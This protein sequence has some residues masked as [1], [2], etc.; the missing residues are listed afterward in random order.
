MNSTH[1]PNFRN[2]RWVIAHALACVMATCVLADEAADP[3]QTPIFDLDPFAVQVTRD[4]GFV[5]ATSQAGG[6]MSTE[7]AETAAAYSVQT[8][9]FLEALNITSSNEALDWTVNATTTPDDGGGQLFGGTGSSTI[10]GVAANQQNRNFF[11]GGSNAPT[12]NVER[13]DYARGPNSVLFGTGSISGTSNVVSKRAQLGT[14]LSEVRVEYGSWDTYG[15]SFDF[16]R[17]LGAD[18]AV[19]VT[20]THQ[21]TFTW[22]DWERTT[23]RG[24]AP[25]FSYRFNQKTRLTVL[26]DV[27]EQN[28][29]RGMASLTDSV[30]GWDGVTTYAGIQPAVAQTQ[31]GASR[32]FSNSFIWNPASGAPANALVNQEGMMRTQ[33]YLGQ[34]PINGVWPLVTTNLGLNLAPILDDPLKPAGIYDAAIAGSQFRIP[35]RK[36][37]AIGPNLTSYNKFGSGTLFVDHR[38][39]ENISLQLSGNTNE[40]RSYGFIGYFINNGYPHVYIDLNQ[41]LHDGTPNPNFL[42][43]YNEFTRPERQ[44][45]DTAND[46]LRFAAAYE[47]NHGWA[48]VRANLITA[49]ENEEQLRVRE[50]QVL[51]VDA[52]SRQW[53]LLTSSRARTF[54]YRYYWDQ[55]ERR[56]P[57]LKEVTLIDPVRGTEATYNPLWALATDRTDGTLLARSLTKYAQASTSLA[58][59]Q[60]RLILFGAYRYDQVDRSQKQFMAPMDHPAGYVI[61]GRDFLYRPDAPDDYWVM[62]YVPKDSMGNQMDIARPAVVR[63]RDGSGQAQAVYANDRFQDDYN[64]PSV[65][66]KVSTEAIGAVVNLGRGVSLWANHAETFNPANLGKTTINFGTPDSS[67][68][69][70][71]DIGIRYSLG[72]RLALSLSYYQS[73]EANAEIVQPSGYSNINVI[74]QSNPVGDFSFDGRNI[75]NIGDRPP[76][77]SDQIDR[78]TQGWEFELTANPTR[79]WRVTANFGTADAGQLNAYRQTRDWVA[80]NEAVLRQ[81]LEDAGV[82]FDA[83]GVAT[84]RTDLDS[85]S[86][87]APQAAN[88]WNALQA[89]RANWVSGRQLMFQSTRWTANFYTDV[90]ITETFLK[91][92]R[93]GY[94]MQ[95]RGKQVIGWRGADTM[96]NPNNP[97]AAI[98]NPDVDALTPVYR[99]GFNTATM[100]I[101]YPIS[102]AKGRQVY[103]NLSID[104]LWNL[105]DP[106]Y[107]NTRMRPVNG[108]L[109]TP[110]REAVA[111]GYYYRAPRNFRLSAK[112][113]F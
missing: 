81:I 41:Q 89:A 47:K 88:A 38:V 6:R 20:G 66:T 84:V 45:V 109:L 107:Y 11:R 1:T 113:T 24:I 92:L 104:N 22:R 28:V 26:T 76:Y 29:T 68:S 13:M 99:K 111:S 103:I 48:D 102:L 69:V 17:K 62:S 9:E 52:D 39:N 65:R 34:R 16:N 18:A 75:R 5:A 12:Y 106:I 7:L 40:N 8:R 105:N 93:I 59:W 82:Q 25:K 87:D 96:V 54:G 51:P 67:I 27:Y 31:F 2:N 55:T 61:T 80:D 50:Y 110:A 37:T 100:T 98:D 46:T 3:A 49:Y 77:W 112:Y 19:R 97:N 43:P 56:I 95:F 101:G 72:P 4:E 64:P 70:G 71:T 91:G 57:D 58:F 23:R 15:L 63:P 32:Y 14:D 86:P 21:D 36:F 60:R 42:K 85:R 30:S 94:G 53:G 108:D 35:D 10:R 83:N 90:R 44:Y 73:T 33:G 78:D 74:L 79:Y